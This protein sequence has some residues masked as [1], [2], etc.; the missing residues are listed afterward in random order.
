V[1]QIPLKRRPVRRARLRP[2]EGD[3]ASPERW[4]V[5]RLRD[6]D[7]RPGVRD[8][9]SRRAPRDRAGGGS[10]CG[11]G[12][13]DPRGTGARA[14]TVGEVP[15]PPSAADSSECVSARFA[16]LFKIKPKFFFSFFLSCK[17]LGNDRSWE[18]T[19][20]LRPRTPDRP[21]SLPAPGGLAPGCGRGDARPPPGAPGPPGRAHPEPHRA[22]REGGVQ[23]LCPL[24]LPLSPP[25]PPV[26][27]QLSRLPAGA[28][29]TEG[30]APDP[31]QPPPG[32]GSAGAPSSRGRWYS[33][34]LYASC[35]LGCFVFFFSPLLNSVMRRERTALKDGAFCFCAVVFKVLISFPL[36]FKKKLTKQWIYCFSR[37]K[38]ML[39]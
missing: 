14:V 7:T 28:G 32:G 25:R 23:L 12:S 10:G 13:R 29:G 15:P 18:S 9:Q 39:H 19:A 22:G 31:C 27:V 20:A 17:L 16:L 33:E 21:G 2:S 26:P 3:G 5:P 34:R 35:S 6:P 24:H 30:A 36:R 1:S 11:D 37:E 4:D 38:S 8:G